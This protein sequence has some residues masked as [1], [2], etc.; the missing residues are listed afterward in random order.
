MGEN[1]ACRPVTHQARFEIFEKAVAI[2]WD[3]YPR[4]LSMT[5]VC[6]RL[7]VSPRHLQ[8]VFTDRA[9]M[10]FR[11]YLTHVRMSSAAQLLTTTEM[12]VKEVAQRVGYHDASQFTKAFKRTHA[13]SP[14]QWRARQR[15]T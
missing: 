3:E 1:G 2:L 10:G 9:G 4:K 7:S 13:V 5:E 11:A 8:R 14:T 12:P 6:V 15:Q